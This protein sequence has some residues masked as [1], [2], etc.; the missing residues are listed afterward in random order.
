MQ[1]RFY[2]YSC[3]FGCELVFSVF[4]CYC[5]VVIYLIEIVTTRIQ[6][7]LHYN[8]ELTLSNFVTCVLHNGP[9]I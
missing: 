6:Y 3:L 2:E 5:Y 4:K 9:R 8:V 1:G 7:S